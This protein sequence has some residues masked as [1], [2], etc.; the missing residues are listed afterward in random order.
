[1]PTALTNA[2]VAI[3]RKAG[4]PDS[5]CKDIEAIVTLLDT[6]NITVDWGRFA[7]FVAVDPPNV[8]KSIK[9]FLGTLNPPLGPPAS[10]APQIPPRAIV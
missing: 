6:Y 7:A 4:V 5:Y 8:L 9:D 3:L 10:P 2:Q 1:M